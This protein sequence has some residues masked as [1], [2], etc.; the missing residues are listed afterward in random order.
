[1]TKR[2]LAAF[3]SV[4][5]QLEDWFV[6]LRGGLNLILRFCSGIFFRPSSAIFSPIAL[7]MDSKMSFEGQKNMHE[8]ISQT[9]FKPPLSRQADFCKFGQKQGAACHCPLRCFVMLLPA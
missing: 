6:C 8:Q 9:N 5:R 3:I 2:L 4:C 1:M 7:A